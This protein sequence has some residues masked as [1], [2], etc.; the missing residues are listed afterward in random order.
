MSV[1]VSTRHPLL[2]RVA[3]GARWVGTDD[4]PSCAEWADEEERRLR[5]LDG[6]GALDTFLPRLRG[7]RQQRDEARAEIMVA[8]FL[9]STFGCTIVA[10]EPVGAN[11]RT[12]DL[13]VRSP[14]TRRAIF[15]EV[16]APGYEAEVPEAQRRVRRGQLKYGTGYDTGMFDPFTAVRYAVTKANTKFPWWRPTLLV[17]VDDMM[18]PLRAVPDLVEEALHRRGN[19]AGGG[20]LAEDGPFVRRAS[21]RLGAVATLNVELF[22][23]MRSTFNMFPNPR[24][25]LTTAVPAAAFAGAR[26]HHGSDWRRKGWRFDAWRW[27]TRVADTAAAA[28]AGGIPAIRTA[29]RRRSAR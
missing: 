14:H 2:R 9:V 3:Q 6:V 17:I 18:V 12:G 28:S 26:S 29:T 4:F 24:A 20:W 25:L 27:V 7:S 23:T 11:R 13:L 10:W 1:I 5:F 8:D 22:D 19:P 16:K 15:V 21:S